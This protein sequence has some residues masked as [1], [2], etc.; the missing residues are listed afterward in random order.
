MI[1][2]WCLWVGLSVIAFCTGCCL[3]L[4]IL[5]PGVDKIDGLMAWWMHTTLMPPLS[6]ASVHWGKHNVTILM[7]LSHFPMHCFSH[8]KV[9]SMFAERVSH[10]EHQWNRI[11]CNLIC[12][13]T[14]CINCW[15]FYIIAKLFVTDLGCFKMCDWLLGRWDILRC[16]MGQQS[17]F[18]MMVWVKTHTSA[19]S[20]LTA[21]STFVCKPIDISSTKCQNV[22]NCLCG[23]CDKQWVHTLSNAHNIGSL[24]CAGMACAKNVNCT[25]HI[26]EAKVPP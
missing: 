3:A 8:I 1:F 17:I 13:T 7:S 16:C 12:E 15:P 5:V 19:N 11:A 6:F 23:H 10:A 22:D 20:S 4:A 9:S 26:S 24:G 18:M 25:C 14:V 21:D 2:L